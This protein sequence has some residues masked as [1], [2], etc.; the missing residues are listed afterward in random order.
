VLSYGIQYM[1]ELP[2]H[3]CDGMLLGNARTWMEVIDAWLD[4]RSIPRTLRGPLQRAGRVA[5]E[6]LTATTGE[7]SGQ[8]HYPG[9]E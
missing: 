2:G 8:S 5:S 7:T 3:P 9:T 4:S 6:A 1:L